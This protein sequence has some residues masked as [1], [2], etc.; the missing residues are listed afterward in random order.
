LVWTQLLRNDRITRVIDLPTARVPGPLPQEQLQILENDGAL[1][2][3]GGAVA[4]SP[5]FAA[6]IG[7]HF[8]GR[9]V[10]TAKKLGLSLWAV[11][12]PPRIRTWSQG[13]QANGDVPQGGVATLDV[14]DCGRGTFH[15]VAIGRDNETLRLSENGNP[16]ATTHLWREGVWEQTIQTPAA[17][18]TRCSFSLSTTSLVHLA[19]F[20]WSPG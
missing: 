9:R 17:T 5:F 6:P 1:R 7:I 14:F 11:D 16:V 19:A 10:V 15:V 3:V 8:T 4:E 2:L 20:G 12:E 13:L 18:G